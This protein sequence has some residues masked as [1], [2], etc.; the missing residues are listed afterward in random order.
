MIHEAHTEAEHAQWGGA[1]PGA[2]EAGLE[3]GPPVAPRARGRPAPRPWIRLSR[4]D[5]DSPDLIGRRVVCPVCRLSFVA[6]DVA[7]WALRAQVD[8][9]DLRRRYTGP[10]PI[11]YAAVACPGCNYAALGQDWYDLPPEAVPHLRDALRRVQAEDG[12]TGFNRDRDAA[13]ARRAFELARRCYDWRQHP[14]GHR[15]QGRLALYIAWC[16]SDVGDHEGEHAWQAVA[17]RELALAYERDISLTTRDELVLGYLV[18]ELS[19]RLGEPERAMR[20]FH[21]A[22]RHPSVGR[23]PAW[24]RRIRDGCMRSGAQLPR[25]V[26]TVSAHQGLVGRLRRMTA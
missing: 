6:W 26:R 15:L 5:V 17:R 1:L 25:A 21:A 18:G 24:E 3:A 9:T 22:L 20:Y 16:A 12:L 2:V 7:P 19:L 10:D 14:V 13:L 11:Y 8:D 23:H 4:P